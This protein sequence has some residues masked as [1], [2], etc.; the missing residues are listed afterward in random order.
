M[1][2]LKQNVLGILSCLLSCGTCGSLAVKWWS[3]EATSRPQPA[4]FFSPRFLTA[5]LGS[6]HPPMTAPSESGTRIQ[7]VAHTPTHIWTSLCKWGGWVDRPAFPTDQAEK[8]LTKKFW[9]DCGPR[10]LGPDVPACQH[11]YYSPLTQFFFKNAPLY[12]S[13]VFSHATSGGCRP[14][15]F[16]VSHRLH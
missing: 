7:Q 13:S 5:Q 12:L 4:A 2:R 14:T 8:T 16:S 3:T 10:G 11:P 6:Q 1:S 15:G 9:L